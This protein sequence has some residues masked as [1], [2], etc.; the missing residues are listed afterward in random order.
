[1]KDIGVKGM[2]NGLP[3]L[4]RVPEARHVARESLHG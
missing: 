1:M 4:R 3:Q 2:W